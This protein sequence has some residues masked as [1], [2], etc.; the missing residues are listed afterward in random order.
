MTSKQRKPTKRRESPG[1][2][3]KRRSLTVTDLGLKKDTFFEL[4]SNLEANAGEIDKLKEQHELW[5]LQVGGKKTY[6]LEKSAYNIGE[7]I[8][9]SAGLMRVGDRSRTKARD[10]HELVK[11]IKVVKV[12]AGPG[13]QKYG[14]LKEKQRQTNRAK[15][16]REVSK[17]AVKKERAKAERELARRIIN[18]QKKASREIAKAKTK[19]NKEAVKLRRAAK[20]A[21]EATARLSKQVVAANKKA[22]A[23]MKKE[24]AM[25][26]EIAKLKAQLKK[27]RK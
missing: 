11:T 2:L 22:S 5:A 26:R 27:K 18:E 16:V 15:F 14:E 10:E 25:K 6:I 21:K 20:S 1:Y 17:P 24:T 19:A 4:W 3:R 23:A 13:L 9:Q 8:R 12:S 7:K